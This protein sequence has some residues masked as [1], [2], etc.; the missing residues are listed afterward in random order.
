M[1]ASWSSRRGLS[2]I[3]NESPPARQVGRIV[4]VREDRSTGNIFPRA[5]IRA[6][7]VPGDSAPPLRLLPVQLRQVPGDAHGHFQ[8][9]LAVQAGIHLAL[10]GAREVLLGEAAGA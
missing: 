4:V 3:V 1:T 9:L 2:L 5:R 8:G 7:R 6:E 10:V